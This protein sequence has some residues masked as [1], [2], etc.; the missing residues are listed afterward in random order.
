MTCGFAGSMMTVLASPLP[1]TLTTCLSFDRRLPAACA[2]RRTLW[3]AVMTA[4][5]FAATA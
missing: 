3:I 4:A 5:W 2:W 1:C